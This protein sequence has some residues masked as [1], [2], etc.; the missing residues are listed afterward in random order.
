MANSKLTSEEISNSWKGL[1]CFKKETSSSKGLR[2][3]Q[4]G[5]LHALL[6]HIE[7]GENRAFS[8]SRAVLYVNLRIATVG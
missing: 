1:F 8:C 7:D 6:A 2:S 5:A 4:I 3:P